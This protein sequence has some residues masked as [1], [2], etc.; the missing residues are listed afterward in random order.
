MTKLNVLL[1][2]TDTL[3]SSFRAMTSDYIQFFS[4]NQGDFKGELK[5][6]VPKDGMI[7]VPS[8]RSD[9]R[10]VTTVDEKLD[11]F[12]QNSQQ[13]I[14]ALFSQEATNASGKAKAQ[15]IVDGKSWGEFTSLELL[16]LKS[17]VENGDFEKVYSTIPVR[18]DSELW[19]ESKKEFYKDRKVFE[20]SITSGTKKSVTK[21]SYILPDPNISKDNGAKY[22]PQVAVKD[23]IIDLGDYTYQK[24]SGEWSHRERAG[25]LKRRQALLV[26]IVEAL[27]EAN[28]VPAVESTMTSKKL[29]DYLHKGING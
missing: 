8:E 19:E 26:A 1:A 2:K 5:T 15:L 23:T 25:V 18:S 20:S 13:Y 11:W 17:L 24:F 9:K 21:E 4:K 28:D 16:R 6:Y 12:E 29:F 22:V 14:N 7:D 27:K 10:I 3:S